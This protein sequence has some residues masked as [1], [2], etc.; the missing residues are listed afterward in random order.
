MCNSA[1]L[2]TRWSTPADRCCEPPSLFVPDRDSAGTWFV[3]DHLAMA[4]ALGWGSVAPFYI[5]QEDPVPP[6]GLPHP[7][8]LR[9]RLRN[10]HLQY[11]ITWFGLAF[12]LVIMFAVWSSR[13]RRDGAS[14]S[15]AA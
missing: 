2:L 4:Q 15:A 10:D 11:A 6:G 1:R 7:S 13:Q 9:V 8:V 3:R 14:G 12:V 5:E